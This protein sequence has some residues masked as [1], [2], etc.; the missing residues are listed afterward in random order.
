MAYSG[1]AYLIQTIMS[2]TSGLV[3]DEVVNDWAVD[4]GGPGTSTGQLEDA[5]SAV[6]DFFRLGATAGDRVG[7]YIGG[8]IDRGATH[9]IEL[10][11]IVAGP[12][13][14]PLITQD[15]LGPTSAVATSNLPTECAAVLSFH[16]DLTGIFEEVGVTRP[17]ARRRGR[18]FI[19]PLTTGAVVVADPQPVLHNDFRV[20]MQANAVAMFDALATIGAEWSVWSR[21]DQTLRQVVGGWTDNAPDTQRR[22]G[23]AASQ[24]STFT[25]V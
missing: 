5:M 1:G 12:L 3:E 25:T 18:V 24:R 19:G 8:S 23:Q 21:V 2:S 7:S 20:A 10:R 14:P 9:R 16:A 17:R 4:F 22:R 13:G 11:E 15:W 6:G